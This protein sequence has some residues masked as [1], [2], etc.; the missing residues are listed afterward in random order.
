M[1]YCYQ[2]GGGLVK[3]DKIKALL[4]LTGKTNKEFYEYLG[5]TRQSMYLK[6]KKDM[7]NADD[8][9]KLGELTNTLLAFIDQNNKVLLS[10]DYA[11]LRK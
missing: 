7:Y 10:F 6:Q 4:A 1:L 5:I 9:I 3:T 11:D 8:L 2:K